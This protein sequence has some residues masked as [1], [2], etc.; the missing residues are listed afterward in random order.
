MKTPLLKSVRFS[1]RRPLRNEKFF[2]SL[3]GGFK[4]AKNWVPN[5]DTFGKVHDELIEYWYEPFRLPSA[6]DMQVLAAMNI[7][8]HVRYE[9]R[10]AILRGVRLAMETLDEYIRKI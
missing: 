5:R 7:P 4:L 2:I 8:Q 3:H 1:E 6:E 9:E 10:E